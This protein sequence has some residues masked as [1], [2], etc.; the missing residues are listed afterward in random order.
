MHEDSTNKVELYTN[1]HE[2]IL[3]FRVK[4]FKCFNLLVVR[5]QLSSPIIKGTNKEQIKNKQ[6]T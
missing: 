2:L 4:I 5:V 6:R 1:I 3:K